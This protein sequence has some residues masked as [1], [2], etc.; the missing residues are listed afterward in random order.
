MEK[1]L[2]AIS[3][4][5]LVVFGVIWSK[6]YTSANDND[7]PVNHEQNNDEKHEKLF[8]PGNELSQVKCGSP[9]TGSPIVEVE[10]KVQN[11]SDSGQ[12]G[13]YWAFDYYSRSI[14]V[15]ATKAT[16]TYCAVVTYNGKFYTVPGQ[17]GP[18]NT[19]SGAQINTPTNQPINGD[20]SGG[21][22][23]TIVGTLLTTPLWVTHG[24]VGTTNYQCNI[25]GTCPGVISWPGQY[26]NS[27]Y[28][29]NDDWWGWK[30]E[31]GSHGTWINAISGNSGN[32]L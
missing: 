15:W 21:R 30:Y 22:R 16:N 3:I 4:F 23:A 26:F 32:I 14:R 13:N 9:T 31:A 6:T 24:G 18:G 8:N 2:I 20:F 1:L 19:P 12:A 11:D 25:F 17:V 10:Q 7:R 27:G 5:A 29:Y 28:T